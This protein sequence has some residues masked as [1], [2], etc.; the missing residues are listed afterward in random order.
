MTSY[1]D[2]IFTWVAYNC[3]VIPYWFF[4]TL[5]FHDYCGDG[6]FKMFWIG[7]FLKMLGS[8][9]TCFLIIFMPLSRYHFFVIDL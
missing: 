9:V 5:V 8:V 2:K 3:Y 1:Q 4:E 7:R 6:L